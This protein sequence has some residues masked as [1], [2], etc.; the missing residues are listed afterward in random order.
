[1]RVS[2]R[3]NTRENAF[4]LAC[5]SLRLFSARRSTVIDVGLRPELVSSPKPNPTSR[6]GV[7]GCPLATRSTALRL[8]SLSRDATT[9]AL[10]VCRWSQ[11]KGTWR[12]RGS[13]PLEARVAVSRGSL[14]LPS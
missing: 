11:L 14:E 2:N 6:V 3:L 7:Y 8:K 10:R 9:V 1:N 4:T 12:G 13:S 5:P